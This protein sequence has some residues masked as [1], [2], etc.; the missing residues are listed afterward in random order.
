MT[1]N[2]VVTTK[3]SKF[4]QYA[5]HLQVV[6]EGHAAVLDAAPLIAQISNDQVNYDS[7]LI[8]IKPP[9]NCPM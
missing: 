5:D 4:R 9:L 2:H 6:V 8:K 1:A 3:E 7:A